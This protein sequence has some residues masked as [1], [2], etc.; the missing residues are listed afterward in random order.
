MAAPRHTNPE[1]EQA[2]LGG[3]LVSPSAFARLGGLQPGH[4]AS[5]PCRLTAEVL[6]DLLAR[7]V[8]VDYVSLEEELRKVGRLDQVG[9]VSWIAGL[10]DH[11]ASVANV[12]TYSA[13]LLDLASRRQFRAALRAVVDA[14]DAG[15]P[16]GPVAG[17]TLDAVNALTRHQAVQTCSIPEAVDELERIQLGQAPG[18]LATGF[19]ELDRIAPRKG[20]LVLL[21]ALNSVGKTALMNELTG[22]IAS[23]GERALICSLEMTAEEVQFRRLSASAYVDGEAMVRGKL[24]SEDWDRIAAAA[25][26]LHGKPLTVLSG[27]FD[28]AALLGVIRAEHARSPLT[29]CCVDFLGMIRLP[30]ENRHDLELGYAAQALKDL[31][32]ELKLVMVLLAQLNRQSQQGAKDET[33]REPRMSDLRDSGILEH[34][35]DVIWLLHREG[36]WTDGLGDEQEMLV[37]CPKRRGGRS[38]R[39]RL[40]Y[41]LPSQRMRDAPPKGATED[42]D[43]GPTEP[44]EPSGEAY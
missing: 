36:R 17:A 22:R 37:L 26:D 23:R 28:T 41:H 44:A 13:Q 1:L 5:V 19:A 34:I 18:F 33:P 9:G 39:G 21:G 7:G 14:M 25:G 3:L 32:K 30:G 16:I 15:D 12:G 31:A 4:F 11:C 10:T 38:G 2:V 35:A 40:L 43:L 42:D 6:W 27:S 20:Q 8:S 29:I 24:C